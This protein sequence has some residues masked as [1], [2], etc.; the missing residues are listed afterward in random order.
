MQQ[1]NSYPSLPVLYYGVYGISDVIF[2]ASLRRL[3][4]SGGKLNSRFLPAS[5]RMTD[6]QGVRGEAICWTPRCI[7]QQSRFSILADLARV[8]RAHL[9]K[10]VC[11]TSTYLLVRLS[12]SGRARARSAY[13][14]LITV[15][16]RP[17]LSCRILGPCRLHMAND[18]P[19]QPLYPQQQ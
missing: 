17:I 14:P 1:L 10:I 16:R 8:S 9:A 18:L 11:L 5:P 3:H 19:Q 13:P 15:A 12:S 7:M 4:I 6:Q 2:C